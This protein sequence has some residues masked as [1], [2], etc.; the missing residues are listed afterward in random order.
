MKKVQGDHQW[1]TEPNWPSGGFYYRTK[2]SCVWTETEHVLNRYNWAFSWRPLF[3]FVQHPATG[4]YKFRTEPWK[5]TPPLSEK[6]QT[7]NSA[8][9]CKTGC[10]DFITKT[11]SATRQ[12]HSL[13]CA[14]AATV[15]PVRIVGQAAMIFDS[16]LSSLLKCC[17]SIWKVLLRFVTSYFIRLIYLLSDY[18]ILWLHRIV[19]FRAKEMWRTLR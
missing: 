11:A 19:C 9:F 3:S 12:I 7:K 4:P 15:V 13:Q 6:I 5:R 16:W 1:V 14:K 10:R 17:P 8:K 18:V 2:K